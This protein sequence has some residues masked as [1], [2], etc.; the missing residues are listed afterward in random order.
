MEQVLYYLL[1]LTDPNCLKTVPWPITTFKE[2][3]EFRNT[4][5]LLINVSPCSLFTAMIMIKYIYID[6]Y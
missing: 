1:Q 4:A 5:T 3:A 6:T 2:A